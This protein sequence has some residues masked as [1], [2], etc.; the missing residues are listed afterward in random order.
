MIYFINIPHV[1]SY[2]LANFELKTPLVHGEI[3]KD[4]LFFCEKR[5]TL[6]VN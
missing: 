3:K 6:A 5:N 4:Q 1:V 2:E